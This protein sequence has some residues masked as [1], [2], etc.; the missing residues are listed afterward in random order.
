VRAHRR[1]WPLAGVYV[2]G[3]FVVGAAIVFVDRVV[4]P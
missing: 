1:L 2:F 4:S 3:V